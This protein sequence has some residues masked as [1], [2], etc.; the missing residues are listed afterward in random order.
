MKGFNGGKAYH[1]SESISGGKLKGSTGETDYFYFLCPRC[2]N[3]EIVRILEYGIHYKRPE[4]KY[5]VDFKA[6]AKYAFAIV[7]KVRCEKCGLIDF[8]KVSNDGWQGGSLD[9][10]LDSV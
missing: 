9:T 8:V 3:S 2:P 4:N 7:F 10:I 6:K 5:N 1:G